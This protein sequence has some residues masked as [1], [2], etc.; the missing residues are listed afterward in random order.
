MM[1]THT[2]LRNTKILFFLSYPYSLNILKNILFLL[3]S[4]T[5]QI[6]FSCNKWD[7]LDNSNIIKTSFSKPKIPLFLFSC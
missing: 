5:G 3:L 4:G 1:Q 7:I 2:L 6:K